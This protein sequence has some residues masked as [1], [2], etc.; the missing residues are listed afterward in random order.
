MT[1]FTEDDLAR[2][3]FDPAA[4]PERAGLEAHLESCDACRE[5]VE[6]IRTVD[7]AMAEQES[8]DVTEELERSEPL[9]PSLAALADDLEAERARARVLLATATKSLEAFRAAAIEKN[10]AYESAGVVRVLT[11]LAETYRQK[12][13]PFALALA[14]AAIAIG[15]RL[16]EKGALRS[17]AYLGDAFRERAVSLTIMGRYREAEEAAGSAEKHYGRDPFATEHDQAVVLLVR[18]NMYAEMERLEEAQRCAMEAAVRFRRFG[19]T[20]RF[21]TSRLIQ[22]NI[23]YIRR[24]HAAAAAAAE[25]LIPLARAADLPLLLVR[26]LTNAGE[27][28]SAM[29]DYWKAR[30][31]FVE[32]IPLWQALGYRTEMVRA[33]WSLATIRL[34]TGDI[35]AAV[36]ELSRIHTDFEGLGIV[37]DGALARLQ[38]AE[39]LLVAGRGDEVPDILAG[40]VVRFSA[41]GLTRNANMALAYIREALAADRLEPELLRDVR[42]YLEELPSSPDRVFMPS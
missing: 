40:V 26:T 31:Y 27:A 5:T 11:E 35:E 23:E 17:V 10:A 13:P 12:Q 16:D 28:R 42:L 29:G 25:E 37:N 21:L 38:L 7:S 9:P 20:E 1:H 4:F 19:D 8:W 22:S 36:E 15:R 39:A 33:R 14:D 18:A 30:A 41:E 34:S 6:F 24:N 32:A 2:Y 3:A